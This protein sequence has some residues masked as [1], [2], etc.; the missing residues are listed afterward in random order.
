VTKI[1]GRTLTTIPKF[2][3]GEIVTYGGERVK[4]TSRGYVSHPENYMYRGKPQFFYAVKQLKADYAEICGSIPESKLKKLRLKMKQKDY[5]EIK[6]YPKP[7][8]CKCNAGHTLTEI[9]N[10]TRNSYNWDCQICIDRMR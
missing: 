2:K 8:Y 7:K 1:A 9:Y 10:E 6:R 5:E 4:I 3:I